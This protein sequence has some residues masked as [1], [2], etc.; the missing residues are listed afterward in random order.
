MQRIRLFIVLLL[1]MCLALTVILP[2]MAQ[3]GRLLSALLLNGDFEGNFNPYGSGYVAEYWVPYDYNLGASSPQ[4]LRS[5]LYRHDGE[6][7]QQLW[8]D[9]MDWYAGIM[10]TTVLTSGGSGARIQAGKRY[11]VHVWVYS[12]YGG[13]GSALQND[14]ILK[15]V[16]IHPEGGTNPESPDIVWTPWHGQ[17]KLWV[18]I[19]AA[20]M[21]TGGRLTVFIEAQDEESGGQ[22]QFYIDGIWLEEEG[23]PPPTSTPTI[24][25]MPSDTPMPTPIPAIAVLRTIPVGQQPQ[26]IGVLPRSDRFF[27]ANRGENTISSLE[28]FF[29]WQETRLPSGGEHP[30]N[31]AIDAEECRMYVANTATDSVTVFNVCRNQQIASID[32]GEGSAPDGI[33]VLTTS[34][35]I[36]VANS[37]ANSVAVIDGNS[38][39]VDL[40]V[41]TGP[42]PAQIAINP[43][44]NKVYVTNR[45]SLPASIGA[46]TVIDA[47]TQ[48]AFKIIELSAV[49]PVAEP[50]GVAVNPI[51]N[52]VY[53]ALASGQLVIID[54]Q[55][56][57]VIDAVPPPVASGL[58]AV[59]VNPASN[60]VFVS[61]TS[62]NMVFVYDADVERWSQTLTVGAGLYRGISVNPLTHH[63]LVS[64]PSDDTVTVIRDSGV[65]Q[66][67]KL[68]LPIVSKP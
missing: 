51:T 14:K 6:A 48:T 33:A 41:P 18:Q 21:A 23:A 61:S 40:S 1:A 4:F 24:T 62:G 44:T 30:S 43:Q 37:A 3:Q 65:Y 7:S 22:D 68:F 54:G 56:D 16:G 26:G 2:G 63:V 49:D 36:Y 27:V 67:L 47:N 39:V 38:L 20:V 34:N 15:R 32:L 57:K 11:T 29:E 28:G 52:R 10:Q 5:T 13:A 31:V 58:D 45:G 35:T 25:P 46:V 12:V 53:V 60:S 59:A 19:N 8:S 55:S 66:P 9:K 50:G 64:N 42:R 17:D